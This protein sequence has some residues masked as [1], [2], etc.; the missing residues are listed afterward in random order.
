MGA[1]LS[2]VDIR[3]DVTKLTDIFLN[4]ANAPKKIGY[5]FINDICLTVQYLGWHLLLLPTF[6]LSIRNYENQYMRCGTEFGEF[7]LQAET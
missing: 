5:V 3:E 4:Y 1:A 7:N 6:W 2:Y